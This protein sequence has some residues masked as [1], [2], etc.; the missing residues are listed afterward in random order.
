MKRF[1]LT[2][3][4][5]LLTFGLTHAGKPDRPKSRSYTIVQLD[6]ADGAYSGSLLD[7]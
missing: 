5:L 1:I 6:D 7:D 3:A 4:A 2:F